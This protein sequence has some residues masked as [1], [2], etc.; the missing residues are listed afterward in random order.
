MLIRFPAPPG[1]LARSVSV[2]RT[3][4][5]RDEV[6]LTPIPASPAPA[7]PTPQG[8]GALTDVDSSTP[9]VPG[10]GDASRHAI[11]PPKT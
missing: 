5:D 4:T 9:R 6:V 10:V 1:G 2:S 8:A 11:L 3:G 7:T